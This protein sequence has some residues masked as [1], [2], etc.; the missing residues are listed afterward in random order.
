MCLLVCHLPSYHISDGRPPDTEAG[1][2]WARS[3]TRLRSLV[4]GLDPMDLKGPG[5]GSGFR[6]SK[7]GS[8]KQI[9]QDNIILEW[10]HSRYLRILTVSHGVLNDRQQ[11]DMYH[12]AEICCH[13]SDTQEGA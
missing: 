2:V 1:N 8:R 10:Y 6:L 12:A 4:D 5:K 7:R 9:M 11:C 3:Q 13:A